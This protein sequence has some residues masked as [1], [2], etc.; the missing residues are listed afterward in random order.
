MANCEINKILFYCVLEP[1]SCCSHIY[2]MKNLANLLILGCVDLDFVLRIGYFSIAVGQFDGLE[3]VRD[4][5][6]AVQLIGNP[7]V[8]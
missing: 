1:K 8:L 3:G 7:D 4:K 2:A 5:A 6:R